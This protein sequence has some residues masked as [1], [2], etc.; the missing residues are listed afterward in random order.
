V[1][2]GGR[3][4]VEVDCYWLKCITYSAADALTSVEVLFVISTVVPFSLEDNY[5]FYASLSKLGG[6]DRM[7]YRNGGM[8]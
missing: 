7:S 4:C 3:P 6:I 1:G 8:R 2:V 5:K